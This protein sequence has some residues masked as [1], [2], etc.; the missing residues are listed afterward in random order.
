MLASD[1][2]DF[3]GAECTGGRYKGGVDQNAEEIALEIENQKA[4]DK[5]YK[6]W[7]IKY[8]EV[9]KHKQPR[10]VPPEPK[11]L[12]K[13][14]D[15][16]VC[17]RLMIRGLEQSDVDRC[18]SNTKRHKK[19]LSKRWIEEIEE[20]RLDEFAEKWATMFSH[21]TRCR[22]FNIPTQTVRR[23]IAS[24]DER[25][26]KELQLHDLEVRTSGY[27]GKGKDK[28]RGKTVLPPSSAHPGVANKRKASA[29]GYYSTG[30]KNP[31]R[32]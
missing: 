31:R 16:K 22:R 9:P 5:A 13:S 24:Q 14:K 2:V 21:K 25:T 3:V 8:R 6:A 23:T 1:H 29:A 15:G 32:T 17:I 7:K 19:P 12:P 20:P 26:A 28:G 30:G 18:S 10:F 27:G 11:V 4:Y